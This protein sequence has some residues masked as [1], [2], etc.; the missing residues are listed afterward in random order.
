MLT[1]AAVS[2]DTGDCEPSSTAVRCPHCAREIVFDLVGAKD[3]AERAG[4]KSQTVSMWRIRN[5]LPEPIAVVSD[6]PVWDWITQ[7]L[8]WL[9]Q[10]KRLPQS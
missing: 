9:Q 8:P 3:I 7:I 5:L 6:V 2:D 10:T 1:S 4:V